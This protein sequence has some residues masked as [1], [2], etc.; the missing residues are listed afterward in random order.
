MKKI[1]LF[2]LA[3]FAT[4][5]SFAQPVL[6]A[7][8]TNFIIGD[9]F[10]FI[11]DTAFQPIPNGGPNQTWNFANMQNTSSITQNYISSVGSIFPLSNI[12]ANGSGE[13]LFYTQNASEQNTVGANITAGVIHTYTNPLKNL[14]YPFQYNNN[15]TDSFSAFYTNGQTFY[16]KGTTSSLADGY[17][18]IILP[19][20]T[21]SNVLRVKTTQVYSDSVVGIGIM[22]SFNTVYYA[23]YLP[24]FHMPIFNSTTIT[25][26]MM[27]TPVISFKS[28]SYVG[29]IVTSVKDYNNNDLANIE[30]FPNP[31][32]RKLNVHF[33]ENKYE[34]VSFSLTDLKGSN[35]QINTLQN[36]SNY[37]LEA[38]NI[39]SG[40]YQLT[41]I[42]NK[43]IIGSKKIQFINE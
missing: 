2:V 29:N 42:S 4:I 19:N 33:V 25:G 11:T 35:F 40:I 17:G 9:S 12:V 37:S 41:I 20:G 38:N 39:P 24:N 3:I 32:S 22:F 18:T 21:Y 15:F 8:N 16:R 28:N 1:N 34:N 27:G 43:E 26:D 14:M 31:T 23:Y 30:I 7:A 10:T 6:T 36:G 13:Q 5:T